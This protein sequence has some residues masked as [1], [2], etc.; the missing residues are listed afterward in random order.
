MTRPTVQPVLMSSDVAL[1]SSL[2]SHAPPDCPSGRRRR[3]LGAARRAV[4]LAGPQ[5]HGRPGRGADGGARCQP[6]ARPVPCQRDR[7][8]HRGRGRVCASTSGPTRRRC[9]WCG[10]ESEVER[11]LGPLSETASVSESWSRPPRPWPARPRWPGSASAGHSWDCWTLLSNAPHRRSSPRWSTGLSRGSSRRWPRRRTA[12][13]G[14][15][16]PERG[17]PLP[18]VLLM[19]EIVRGGCS[20]AMMRNAFVADSASSSPARVLSAIRHELDRLSHRASD[21]V[22]RSDREALLA[23]IQVIDA[24]IDADVGVTAREVPGVEPP[25]PCVRGPAVCT[26]PP[27][28]STSCSRGSRPRARQAPSTCSSTTNARTGAAIGSSS[29]APPARQGCS[30]WPTTSASTPPC[31][32]ASG[33]PSASA[34]WSWTP[35]S[36][37]SPR[38][39]LR[40]LAT[41]DGGEADVVCAGRRGHYLAYQV[42]NAAPSPTGAWRACCRGGRIPV[43]AGMFSAWHRFARRQAGGPPRTIT[44]LR[45]VRR[46]RSLG[47]PDLDGCRRP[48]L[49]PPRT[50]RHR[51][52][53]Q[54]PGSPCADSSP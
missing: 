4:D 48:P 51:L 17:H 18:A 37:I 2:A 38:T 44:W 41:L 23:R 10:H 26:G 5:A 52:D 50:L 34:S 53:P 19:G 54:G 15:T 42:R 13:A 11:V 43:D 32:P 49:A 16:D 36:R 7:A 3:R 31:R 25:A 33:T 6:V 20:F 45:S 28:R 46:R 24:A 22:V 14:L 27:P 35:T 21:E 9:R 47:L 40:L 8:R 30:A 1:L 29:A 39:Y 12:S